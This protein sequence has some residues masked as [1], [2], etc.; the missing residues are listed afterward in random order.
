[1]ASPLHPQIPNELLAEILLYSVCAEAI[2][3]PPASQDVFSPWT[4]CRISSRWRQVALNEPSLWNRVMIQSDTEDIFPSILMAHTA[5][6]RSGNLPLELAISVRMDSDAETSDDS[7][8]ETSDDSDTDTSD[9]SDADTSDDSDT[10]TSDDSDAD[11]SD[12]LDTDTSD[13]SDAETHDD[14]TFI[15]PILTLITA[16]STR[17]RFLSIETPSSQLMDTLL[18]F[19]SESFISLES[20]H[21]GNRHDHHIAED[22]MIWCNA[23]LLREVD[24]E[25]GD[26]QH[27][28]FPLTLHLPWTQLTTLKLGNGEMVHPL[29]AHSVVAQSPQLIHYEVGVWGGHGDREVYDKVVDYPRGSITHPRLRKLL[30]QPFGNCDFDIFIQPLVLPALTEFNLVWYGRFGLRYDEFF[31]LA[32][33]S[34]FQLKVALFPADAQM[35]DAQLKSIMAPSA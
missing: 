34:Q 13:D 27:L 31:R 7:D 33:R 12:D 24:I 35:D 23:P 11:T 30:V 28:T 14:P 4:L 9:D 26:D 8:T 19:P 29:V 10:E 1:M 17:F 6:S 2:K 22:A 5:F 21:I 3:L 15:D 25:N 18:H 32:E 16:Y 20:I